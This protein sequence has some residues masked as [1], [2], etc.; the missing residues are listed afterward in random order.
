MCLADNRVDVVLRHRE[1]AILAAED[2]VA[3][4]NAARRRR[5]TGSSSAMMVRW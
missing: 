3:R 1:N 2:E 5:V 4:I